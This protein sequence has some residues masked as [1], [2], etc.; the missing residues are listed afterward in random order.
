MHKWSVL[1]SFNW[2]ALLKLVIGTITTFFFSAPAELNIKF[3]AVSKTVEVHKQVNFN[4][5]QKEV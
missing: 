1:Q 5:S 4:L 2:H 3:A